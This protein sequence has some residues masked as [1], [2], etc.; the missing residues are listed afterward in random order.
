VI[1]GLLVGKIYKYEVRLYLQNLSGICKMGITFA[2]ELGLKSF[3]YEK[4]S[5][6]NPQKP[7]RTKDTGLLRSRSGKMKKKSNLL[8]AHH[9]LGAPLVTEKK[10]GIF[11]QNMIRNMTGKF[12]IFFQNFIILM[13]MNKVL[14]IN[15]V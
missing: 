15:K 7:N 12:E 8:V 1:S 3:L 2:Y 14:D 5:T 11:F 6:R 9:L 13:N 10:I 4:S